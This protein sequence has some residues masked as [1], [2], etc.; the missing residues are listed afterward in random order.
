M[1]EQHT[2]NHKLMTLQLM[3]TAQV[4]HSR[5]RKHGRNNLD[6]HGRLGFGTIDP[7]VPD[8][9]TKLNEQQP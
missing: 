7:T 1:V 3:P 5:N 6:S 4:L 2:L 9:Q 8:S